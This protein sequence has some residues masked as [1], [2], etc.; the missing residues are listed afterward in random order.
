MASS[1]SYKESLTVI[2]TSKYITLHKVILSAVKIV[3]DGGGGEI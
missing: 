3:L 1:V 2:K